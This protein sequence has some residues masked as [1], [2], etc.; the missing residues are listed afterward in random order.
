MQK[1]KVTGS[2]PFL[3]NLDSSLERTSGRYKQGL[4]GWPGETLLTRL[5]V[6]QTRSHH[7][8]PQSKSPGRILH[9]AVP[10]ALRSPCTR[11]QIQD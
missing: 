8:C 6:K 1:G 10:V 7:H 11:E 5:A 9:Q 3:P 2:Y 4:R